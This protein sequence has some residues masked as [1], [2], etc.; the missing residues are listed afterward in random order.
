MQLY[1]MRRLQVALGRQFLGNER[2]SKGPDLRIS[3]LDR[4]HSS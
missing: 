3:I 1:P 4:I 2:C